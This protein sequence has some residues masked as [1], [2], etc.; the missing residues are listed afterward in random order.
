LVYLLPLYNPLRLI[1][2]ICMLDHLSGGRLEIGV[3]RGV[4]PFE[5]AYFG[6][7]FMD[8]REIFE[9]ALDVVVAGLRNERLTH[10]G[11]HYRFDGVPMEIKPL[12][13]PN[14]PFW[15]GV[16]SPESL[17]LAARHGM[18]MVGGGPNA[19][20]KEMTA[21][22]REEYMVHKRSVADSNPHIEEP[23]IGAIRHVYVAGDDRE[24]S[25]IAAP[26]YKTYYDNI[27]KLWRDFR[28]LPFYGFTPDLELARKSEVAIAGTTEHVV[29]QVGN[30]FELS[31]CN[32]L[33]L[34][35][36]WGGLSQEDSRRSL[37]R[38]VTRVMP[39]FKSH[40]KV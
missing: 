25:S 32:Y 28:T 20:L 26:A 2:E 17:M 29:Q 8:A 7:S 30:F 18:N 12:Q 23:I 10:R 16:S 38:F 33:V 14:P 21:H 5:L 22:F 9:E 35:F 36:A 31:G 4:S 34:S 24:V 19:A 15:Y 3:G 6:I 39:A 37:D 27:T 1:N 13:Q 11:P 40:L